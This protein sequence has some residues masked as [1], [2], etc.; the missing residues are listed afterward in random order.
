MCIS[1]IQEAR[2]LGASD[3]HLTC[4]GAPMARLAGRLLPL[5]AT[6][7][8][9]AQLAEFVTLL[10][11]RARQ[12]LERRGEVDCAWDWGS[13]RYRLNIYRQKGQYAMAVRLLNSTVPE[14]ETLGLP[15]AL[16]AVTELTQGLA[17]LVGPTGSGKT[18]TLASLVQRINATKAVHIITLEDPIEYE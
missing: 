3:L 5:A 12:Q 16:Q 10:P 13:E 9:A 8:A 14:C 7:V 11:D 15:P 6:P 17:L 18:T 1:L 2:R 4:G